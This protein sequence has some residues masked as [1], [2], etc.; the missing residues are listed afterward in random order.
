MAFVPRFEPIF[1]AHAIE[2]CVATAIF[3]QPL[4]PKVLASLREK[5]KALFMKEGLIEGP[6]AS[7]FQFDVTT[8]KVVPLVDGGPVSY[9]T[10][11]RGTTITVVSNQVSLQ[12]T[13]YIRWASFELM[14]SKF[15]MPVVTDFCEVVSI[16]AVQLGYWD[17]F[18]WSGTWDDF[19]VQ[20]LLDPENDLIVRKAARAPQQWHSHAGWFEMHAPSLRRLVNVNVD[21]VSAAGPTLPSRPSVGIYTS[22]QD[23]SI[24]PDAFALANTDLNSLLCQ[25]HDDLKELLRAIISPTMAQRIGL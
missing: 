1:P 21:V 25:E 6:R 13:R 23:A 18:L 17:R 19:D 5:H 10:P 9:V 15:L 12:T 20:Q 16:T 14:L 11:D 2:Q 7:G 4:P 22:I 3:D 24:D 8:G